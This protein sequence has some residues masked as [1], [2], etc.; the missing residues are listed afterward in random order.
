MYTYYV[1]RNVFLKAL[2]C[3]IL[4]TDTYS[5]VSVRPQRYAKAAKLKGYDTIWPCLCGSFF[6]G[7][8]NLLKNG[9]CS[10]FQAIPSNHTL[11]IT[12]ANLTP[13]KRSF[14]TSLC[15]EAYPFAGYPVLSVADRVCSILYV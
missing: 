5:I 2:P 8:L 1:A 6:F 7:C 9:G 11:F 10:P 3:R 13:R 15:V 14:M 4:R 12:P